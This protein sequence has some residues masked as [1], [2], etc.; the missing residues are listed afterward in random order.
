MKEAT[1]V[2]SLD[3][4][5]AKRVVQDFEYGCTAMR[6]D[7]RDRLKCPRD[8]SFETNL[9]I[10]HFLT[11]KRLENSMGK[12]KKTKNRSDI[13]DPVKLHGALLHNLQFLKKMRS[14][15]LRLAQRDL[16][17]V[18][19]FH[20]MR[21]VPHYAKRYGGRPPHG[22]PPDGLPPWHFA[23]RVT[24][25]SATLSLCQVFFGLPEGN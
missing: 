14:G 3:L 5:N 24:W 2:P 4:G 13:L 18:A 19:V 25:R 23:W 10:L 12:A 17:C 11:I 15:P 6:R 22:G 16:P 20:V 21:H 9:S 7:G 1:W 8:G